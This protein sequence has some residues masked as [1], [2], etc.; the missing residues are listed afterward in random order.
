MFIQHRFEKA[1]FYTPLSYLTIQKNDIFFK[2][3]WFIQKYYANKNLPMNFFDYFLKQFEKSLSS[4][5]L[6][7]YRI[8]E[9]ERIGEFF[10][11]CLKYSPKECKNENIINFSDILY[12]SFLKMPKKSS[13]GKPG[14]F[15]NG[16]IDEHIK[17]MDIFMAKT[18]IKKELFGLDKFQTYMDN[19]KIFFQR[20]KIDHLT[21]L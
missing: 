9:P 11:M 10:S 18:D 4:K 1:L 14:Y 15:Y 16:L 6:T 2:D 20:G 17:L 21:K 13:S 7:Q 8:F 5:D 19:E 3:D 12:K